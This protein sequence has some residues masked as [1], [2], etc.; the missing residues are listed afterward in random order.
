MVLSVFD[1]PFHATSGDSGTFELHL[2][3]GT[4]EMVA[5]HEKYG[6]QVSAIE[7]VDGETLE[8]DFTFE[9]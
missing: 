3:P 4:Y 8:L 7:L 5:W 2:P 9:E 6:A 1:H